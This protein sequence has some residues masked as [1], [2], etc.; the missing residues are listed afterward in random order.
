M[1]FVVMV[2][3]GKTLHHD[4]LHHL[5]IDVRDRAAA[6]DAYHRARLFGAS[7]AKP[8]RTTWKGNPL[9]HEL[10][11]EN[12]DGNLIEIYARL[13]DEELSQMPAS[14][15]LLFLVPDAV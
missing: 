3:D 12:P 5:G 9:H 8:V 7:I 13:T 10:W 2:S 11:L 1:N 6:I 4:T 14:R 15:E